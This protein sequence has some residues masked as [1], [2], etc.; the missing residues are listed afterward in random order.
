MYPNTRLESGSREFTGYIPDLLKEL[1]DIAEFEY[2]LYLVADARYGEL[3]SDGGTW[4][5]MIG[6]IVEG[7][8]KK[9]RIWFEGEVVETRETESDEK[10]GQ[11]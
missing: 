6:D 11:V 4:N 5:G 3:L 7:V 1:A 9:G 2:D 10:P 8:R